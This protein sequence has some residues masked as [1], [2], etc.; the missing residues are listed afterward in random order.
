MEINE[1]PQRI[2]EKIEVEGGCWLWTAKRSDEG[3]GYVGLEGRTRIAHRVTYELLIGPIPDGLVL[4]HTCTTPP[5]VNPTH[6]EPVTQAENVRRS[7][8]AQKDACVNGHAYT[9]ENTYLRPS[10]GEGR[11]D[12][13]TCIR[14]RVRRYI[15]RKNG[16]AA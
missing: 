8:P 3:Y 15:A 4:D 9:P 1:L 12:C 5:C 2:A 14:E 10:R 7:A 13:R 16:A 11:R 6:L